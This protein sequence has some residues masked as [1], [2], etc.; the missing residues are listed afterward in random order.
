M[1]KIIYYSKN[2]ECNKDLKNKIGI[3][4]SL[5]YYDIKEYINGNIQDNNNIYFFL[6]I[7]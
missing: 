2:R 7:Y 1:G 5:I 3:T 4:S 6:L